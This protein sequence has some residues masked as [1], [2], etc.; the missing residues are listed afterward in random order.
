MKNKEVK[1]RIDILEE[2]VQKRMRKI[3]SLHDPTRSNLNET[4]RT[5]NEKLKPLRKVE[6]KI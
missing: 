6:K 2:K 3:V 5:L 4:F 1:R